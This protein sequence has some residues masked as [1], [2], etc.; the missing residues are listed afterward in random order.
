M[1]TFMLKSAALCLLA[2]LPAGNKESPA[3]IQSKCVS[4]RPAT[5]TT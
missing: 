1:K 3:E 5:A 2:F 4:R